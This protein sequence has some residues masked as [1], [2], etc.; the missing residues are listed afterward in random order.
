MHASS[1]TAQA[2]FD[3]D[4]SDGFLV[5]NLTD[6]IHFTLAKQALE[7]SLSFSV[8]PAVRHSVELGQSGQSKSSQE[9][10]KLNF[11]NPRRM[12]SDGSR[13]AVALSLKQLDALVQLLPRS[14]SCGRWGVGEVSKTLPPTVPRSNEAAW[15][16][17]HRLHAP[18]HADSVLPPCPT[19]GALLTLPST[20]T[21]P[22]FS[23]THL[24]RTGAGRRNMLSIQVG[25]NGVSAPVPCLDRP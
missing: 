16:L 19:Q 14:I 5:Y 13:S 6:G 11:I 8:P 1:R 15:T 7:L 3:H 12:L 25:W 4:L 9:Q 20:I 10:R 24:L 23:R 2:D 22:P 21:F 17:P 18:A